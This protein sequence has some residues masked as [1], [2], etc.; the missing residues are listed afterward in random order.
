SVNV[1]AE[2]R[3]LREATYSAI[4]VRGVVADPQAQRDFV[5]FVQ[6]NE[7]GEVTREQHFTGTSSSSY[8][9]ID[10]VYDDLG[11]AVIRRGNDLVVTETVY[12]E[13]GLVGRQIRVDANAGNWN[14]IVP[15][16]VAPGPQRR[17]TVT[18]YDVLARWRAA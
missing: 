3:G 18:Q 17:E 13:H 11:R 4:A 2:D 15:H 14:N 1:Y 12:D 10:Y 16:E 5:K 9:T 8:Q 7:F 6:H